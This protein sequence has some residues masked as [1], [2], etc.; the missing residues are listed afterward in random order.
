[1]VRAHNKTR[2]VTLGDRV[3]MSFSL[4]RRLKGLLGRNHLAPGEGMWIR[5]CSSIHTFFMRFSIDA[6][7]LSRENVVLRR[8]QN[9]KPYR[10]TLPVLGA[11]AVLEL[12]AGTLAASSTQEGDQ[13]EFEGVS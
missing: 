7:F 11:H 1:M 2:D 6:A 13:I 10:V 4:G 3:E 9:L 8:E 12:P 5:P